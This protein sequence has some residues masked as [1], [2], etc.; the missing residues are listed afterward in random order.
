MSLYWKLRR[1][2]FS[3]KRKLRF[4]L[5]GERKEIGI[6]VYF[7]DTGEKVGTVKNI[8]FNSAGGKI[9]YEIENDNGKVLYFPLDAFEKRKRGLIFAPLWYSEGLKLVKDLEAKAK[10]PDLHELILQEKDK[11]MLYELIVRRRP[12]IRK[13]VEEVL[14]LKEALIKRLNDLETRMVM[15]RKELVE[16]SGKRL[17]KEISKKDFAEKVIEARR[18]MNIVEIGMKRCRE[19]LFR[20]ES[21]PFLP[22]YA[23]KEEE[24]IAP[25]RNIL[26]NIPV[27]IIILNE[28]GKILGGNEHVEKNFGYSMSEMKNRKFID[29]V[30]F[31]DK[32]RIEKANERIFSGSEAEEAE[33]EFVDKYGVHHLLYG[34]FLGMRKGE[35]KISIFAFHTKEEAKGLKKIFSERVAHLFFNPLCIAQ[36]YLHLLSEEKYGRLTEEQRKQIETIEKNLGRIEKLI[37]ETI[38]LKP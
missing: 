4:S 7:E 32:E 1:L 21:I 31:K 29:F 26:Q 20:I 6:P 24:E 15:L 36:G 2:I 30:A 14:L 38:K 10:M 19:L 5:R 35:A 17:L 34:R 3:M 9:G 33:F 11:E 27:N 13:Y 22:K 37:K 25:L 16:L 18:E 8:V 12:E 23:R 28:E